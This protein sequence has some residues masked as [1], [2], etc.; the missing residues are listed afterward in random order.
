MRFHGKRKN[1]N[2][3]F[4][5]PGEGKSSP[6]KEE[7]RIEYED[8]L[9]IVY[10]REM[11][12]STVKR[13]GYTAKV[14]DSETCKSNYFAIFSSSEAAVKKAKTWVDEERKATRKPKYK[15]FLPTKKSWQIW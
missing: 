13:T 6:V 4:P 15:Y 8:C 9:I 11:G 12:F 3:T 14:L 2:G 7:Q 1:N 10:S 5:R